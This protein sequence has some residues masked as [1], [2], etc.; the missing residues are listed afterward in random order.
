MTIRCCR[1]MVVALVA[2]LAACTFATAQDIGGVCTNPPPDCLTDPYG[3]L[4]VANLV[5]PTGCRVSVSYT[6]RCG[7]GTFNDFVISSITWDD[8]DPACWSVPIGQIFDMAAI[9]LLKSVLANNPPCP[10]GTAQCP[11]TTT[12]WRGFRAPCGHRLGNVVQA[13]PNVY[14]CCWKTYEVCINAEGVSVTETGTQPAT[15][16]CPNTDCEPICE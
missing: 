4:Q 14:G 1:M 2:A 6:V 5:L 13:C 8:L 9:E 3:P 12:F 16:V 15:T 11:A 10:G 7:C